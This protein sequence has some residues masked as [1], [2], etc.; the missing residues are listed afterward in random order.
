MYCHHVR[1]GRR[2]RRRGG[3]GAMGGGSVARQCTNRLMLRESFHP[4]PPSKGVLSSNSSRARAVGGVGCACSSLGV[5][6][7][8]AA[9]RQRMAD[10]RHTWVRGRGERGRRRLR[11]VEF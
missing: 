5:L 3:G 6:M 8:R 9:Q 7:L 11:P 10:S 4:A 2:R 1:V